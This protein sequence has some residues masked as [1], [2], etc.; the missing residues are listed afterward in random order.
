ME[1]QDAVRNAIEEWD[2]AIDPLELQRVSS[3][4]QS[5][6][7]IKFQDGSKETVDGEEI[8]GRTVTTFDQYG[9]L[10]DSTVT[11]YNE[12]YGYEFDTSAIEQVVRQEMGHA[13]GLGHANFDGSL[14]AQRVNEGTDKISECE[15]KDVIEANY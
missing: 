14:M 1:Q 3:K 7:N 13:L 11:I 8:A 4:T 15:I 6:I 9:F 12:P 5:D 2:L 10:D